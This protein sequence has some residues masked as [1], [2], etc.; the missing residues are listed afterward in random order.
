M[1]NKGYDPRN[2]VNF[3]A[4]VNDQGKTLRDE[5]NEAFEL[6][7]ENATKTPDDVLREKMR[8]AVKDEMFNYILSIDKSAYA[9]ITN[10]EAVSKTILINFQYGDVFR[11]IQTEDQVN[12]LE[13]IYTDHLNI[14]D[15]RN[16]LLARV[17][18]GEHLTP[19][20]NEILTQKTPFEGYL[21]RYNYIL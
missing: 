11:K 5:I 8:G 1:A 17:Q 3:D 7:K 21:D 9:E 6:F 2:K 18:A 15:R 10:N 19:E 16:Q 20:E 12:R 13:N 4:K 14:K